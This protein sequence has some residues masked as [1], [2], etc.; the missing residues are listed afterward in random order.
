MVL[1]LY[2]GWKTYDVDDAYLMANEYQ[3]YLLQQV[4][5]LVTD[6]F[7]KAKAGELLE[8]HPELTEKVEAYMATYASSFAARQAVLEA[9]LDAKYGIKAGKTAAW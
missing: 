1:K 9:W 6:Y 7:T 5:T 2:F 4:P 3:A 8:K